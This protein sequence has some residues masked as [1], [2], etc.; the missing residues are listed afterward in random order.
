MHAVLVLLLTCLFLAPAAT[1]AQKPPLGRLRKKAVFPIESIEI[2]T[3]ASSE[4]LLADEMLFR[5]LLEG[6]VGSYSFSMSMSMDG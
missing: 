3:P 1:T 6:D 5:E 4:F 2:E